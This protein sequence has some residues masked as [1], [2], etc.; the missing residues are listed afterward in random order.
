MTNRAIYY[1][2]EASKCLWHADKVIDAEIR[3]EL[4]ILAAQY[5]LRAVVIENKERQFRASRY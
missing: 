4:R 3:E 5:I 2:D 1:R